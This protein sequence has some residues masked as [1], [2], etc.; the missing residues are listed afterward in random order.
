M[1]K[2]NL[3]TRYRTLL[4][5]WGALFLSIGSFFLFTLFTTPGT[6]I[7]PGQAA[8]KLLNV[9]L[10]AV[11]I[12]LV[13]VSFA[14]KRKLLALA[15]E[16]QDI[17]LVQRAVVVAGAMCEA[18]VLIGVVQHL[19][20]GNREYYLLFLLGAIGMLFHFPR[21]NHL[22]AATYKTSRPGATS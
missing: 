17:G 4:T 2:D 7:E 6:T 13:L 19:P 21:R 18:C 14:V 1:T 15:V 9:V 12:F 10:T 11:G 8:N 3:E 22:L 20:P 16:K 5:L